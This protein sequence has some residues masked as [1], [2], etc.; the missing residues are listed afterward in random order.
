MKQLRHVLALTLVF[1]MVFGMVTPSLAVSGEISVEEDYGIPVE[2]DGGIE[3]EVDDRSDYDIDEDR[4]K[5][6]VLPKQDETADEANTTDKVDGYNYNIIHLDCGRKYFS[7]DSIKKIIDNA[8]AAGFNYIQLA[9]GN[10]GMRF[11][12]DDMS[13]TVNGTTYDGTAITAAI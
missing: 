12:L 11:L 9:V 2:E 4:E 6:S 7:V 13:L 8:S 3:I 10:D 1:C 5:L